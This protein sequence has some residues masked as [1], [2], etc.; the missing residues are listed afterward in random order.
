M[1]PMLRKLYLIFTLALFT[2][3]SAFATRT[4][5]SHRHTPSLMLTH[6]RT[7]RSGANARAARSQRS[8]KKLSAHT[9]ARRTEPSRTAA[10]RAAVNRAGHSV[11]GRATTAR[12]TKAEKLK[13]AREE[14][15]MNRAARARE[16]RAPHLQ[17]AAY[18]RSAPAPEAAPR[19]RERIESPDLNPEASPEVSPATNPDAKPDPKRMPQPDLQPHLENALLSTARF[20]SIPDSRSEVMP[21]PLKGSLESLERQN[22]RNDAEGLER[23]LDENDLRNRIAEK[24]LVPVP[25]SS[26][27]T[28]DEHL[29]ETH[30]YCKPWTATFLSDLAH[31]HEQRFADPLQLSSAVRTVAYQKQLMHVNGNATAAEG[32]IASPHLTGATIDIAKNGM[33]RAEIAWMRTHL[34]ALQLAGKI[35]VEE[36]FRQPCFHITVYT[37]YMQPGRKSHAPGDLQEASEDLPQ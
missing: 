17:T 26:G 21:A 3:T 6:R 2:A 27:L 24:L 15:A 31:A 11:R 13:L 37:S 8:G 12:L 20:P 18:T 32:D 4:T 10:N 16:A 19:R 36:E 1:D 28:I 9:A 29:P 25:V 35:D 14:R 33:G 34:L 30:R 7:H 22:E 23:I 5:R